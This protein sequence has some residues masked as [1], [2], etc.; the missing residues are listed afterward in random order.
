MKTKTKPARTHYT[1]LS[2]LVHWIP[3][4]LP[5]KI[6]KD[7]QA[8]IRSFSCTSHVIALFYGQLNYAASLN[9]ICDASWLHEAEL[10]RIRGKRHTNEIRLRMPTVRATR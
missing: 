3:P 7:A 9:E 10:H 1:V 4:G 6:A 8:D 5:D 2:Q